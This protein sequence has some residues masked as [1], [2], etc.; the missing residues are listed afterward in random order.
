MINIDFINGTVEDFTVVLSNRNLEKQGQILNI[1]DFVYK[2]DFNAANEISFSVYKEVDGEQEK[3][4]NDI[5]DLKLVWLKESN[6]FYQITVSKTES[7]NV[8]KKITGVSLCEAELSQTI[9]RNTEINSE[10]DIARDD[11]VVTTFYHPNDTKGSLLHRILSFA[12]HY[13]IKHVDKS[14]W[15]IQRTFSIDETSVYDFLVGD[16]AEQ[17]GCLFQF[18]SVDR[19][20]SVYDLYTVC[21]DCKYRGEYLDVCPECGSENLYYYGEDTT[22]FVSAGNLADEIIF[23]TD[24]DS[25]KNCMLLKTGDEVMDAAV[26]ACNPNGSQYIYY[27][28]EE[29]KKDMPES[30]KNKLNDYDDLVENYSEEYQSLSQELYECIDDILYY[31]SGMMPNV[32][33]PEVNATTEAKKLTETNLS[34]IGMSLVSSYTSTATVNSALKNFAKVFVKSG[35]V[36]IEIASGT[37]TYTGVDNKGYG[38]GTWK[39]KF[40]VTNHSDEEDIAYSKELTIKVTDDYETFLNQKVLKNIVNNN[41]D[42]DSVFDVLGIDDL[43]N[44]K[45]ALTLY[46]YNRLESFADAIQGVI[47]V[48]I[49]ENQGQSDATYYGQLYTPYY[50]KLQAC[51]AEM[52]VRASSIEYLEDRQANIIK[53]QYEIQSALNMEAFLGEDLYKLFCSYRREDTYKND[54]FISDG[55]SNEEI[56]AKAKEFIELATNEIVKSGEHQ[57]SISSNLYNLLIMEEFAPLKD[58]FDLG[59]WIRIGIDDDVYRL[60]LISYEVNGNS[61]SNINTEFSEL[62]KTANGVNDVKSILDKAQ[63]MA[64][65]YQYVSKQ[66]E[67]GKK[68]QDRLTDFEEEGLNSTLVNIKNNNNEEVTYDKYGILCKTWDDIEEDYSPEQLRITHNLLAFTDD[69]WKSTTLGLGKHDYYR[70]DDGILTKHVGY[71]L[72]A[73]FLNSPYMHGGQFIGGEIYSENYSDTQGTYLNLND[74]KFSLAGGK[75]KYDG[76]DL[77]LSGVALKWAD[78]S[79]APTDLSYFTNDAGFQ[80][81]DQVTTITE[82]TI[83]T[84]NVI[85]KNLRVQSANIEGEIH[86]N[87]VNAENI[88]GSTFTGKTFL[89]GGENNGDGSLVVRDKNGDIIV[90]IGVDGIQ[91]KDGA[92]NYMKAEELVLL[93][94]SVLDKKISQFGFNVQNNSL[95]CSVSSAAGMNDTEAPSNPTVKNVSIENIDLTDYKKMTITSTSSAGCGYG[96]CY[97]KYGID[98]TDQEFYSLP[99]LT[100]SQE[101]T[102]VRTLDISKY[103]GIHTL[104]FYLYAKSDS[105]YYGYGCVASLGLTSIIL[106]N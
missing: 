14:L 83:A 75:I 31:Q 48:L 27:F 85:A 91:V 65:S 42:D 98:K 5:Y 82:N 64:T 63:S 60:R 15:D 78:L 44:F 17:F 103:T 40:K 76:K 84:T 69:N 29:Q 55:L 2:E 4:W 32:E 86:A 68:A 66:A 41:T 70:F 7:T 37:F 67:Q 95:Y 97:V 94:G 56:F 20:I 92:F 35:F 38:Y 74:G 23:D 90:T 88:I 53:R 59:N 80:T 43:E 3:L 73:K 57:H 106:H 96:S 50:N 58:K 105:S 26:I 99:Y 13:S 47:N 100:G 101:R 104:K 36:K 12:P 16:C 62:T 25:I 61:L 71:G 11:Y 34:P 18:N 33:I 1:Q 19:S 22:I 54:N 49:E 87:S 10:A 72:S 93:S 51:Q 46:S 6:E 79:D 30:L 9:V 28:S 52:N 77:T 81:S 21:N 89:L 102:T 24:I 8:V 39:G 45:R